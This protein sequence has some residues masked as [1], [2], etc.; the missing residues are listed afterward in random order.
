ML[1]EGSII[2]Y[3]GG[4]GK[5]Q[6]IFLFTPAMQFPSTEPCTSNLDSQQGGK[7]ACRK[8]KLKVIVNPQ[9]SMIFQK[10]QPKMS[11]QTHLFD[12]FRMSQQFDMRSIPTVFRIPAL[13]TAICNSPLSPTQK[14]KKTDRVAT[15][16]A[17][18]FNKC[19]S[20]F[21]VRTGRCHIY[22]MLIN[23][24]ASRLWVL[25]ILCMPKGKRTQDSHE[26]KQAHSDIFKGTTLLSDYICVK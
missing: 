26:L 10:C 22:S 2:M 16:R 19:T 23:F 9:A 14:V 1:L 15:P 20:S 21:S 8:W 24:V 3:C 6:G 12:L 11:K 17:C 4:N 25:S 18:Q 7:S 13:L 5:C